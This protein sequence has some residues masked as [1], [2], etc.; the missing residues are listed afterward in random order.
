LAQLGSVRRTEIN[1]I[2]V[3]C[4]VEL[5]PCGIALTAGHQ[6]LGAR[7]GLAASGATVLQTRIRIAVMVMDPLS[8]M[9]NH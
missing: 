4:L 8:R 7:H 1:G 2:I 3:E 6:P 5:L 9:V